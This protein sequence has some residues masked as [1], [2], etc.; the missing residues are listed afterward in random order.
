MRHPSLSKRCLKTWIRLLRL[1]RS[2]EAQLREC[3][4]TGFDTTLPRFEV[5]AALYRR[6]DNV[7]MSELSRLLLILNGNATAVVDRLTATQRIVWVTPEGRSAPWPGS[8]RAR[9]TA[10]RPAD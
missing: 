10:H 8:L 2:V 9:L 6:R 1:T 7:T 3:L 5:M 4:R